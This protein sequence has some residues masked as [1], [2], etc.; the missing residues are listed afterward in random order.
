VSIFLQPAWQRWCYGAPCANE[1]AIFIHEKQSLQLAK[2]DYGYWKLSTSQIKPGDEYWFSINDGDGYP[3]PASLSQQK[4]VHGPSTAIDLLE[5]KW[6]DTDWKNTPW[7]SILYMS[8]IQALFPK[9]ILLRVLPQ[10]WITW[11]TLELQLSRSCRSHNFPV[12]AK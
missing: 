3:D 10:N 8:C 9:S 11:Q 2:G 12:A 5:Y 7:K 1:A 6:S 4:G